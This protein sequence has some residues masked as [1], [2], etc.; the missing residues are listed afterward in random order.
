MVP[1]PPHPHPAVQS[2]S[3]QPGRSPKGNALKEF[4]LSR[5]LTA[6]IQRRGLKGEHP[7][8]ALQ[9]FLLAFLATAALR[10]APGAEAATARSRPR[11]PSRPPT[12]S[13]C[14][15]LIM[16]FFFLTSPN[17]CYPPRPPGTAQVMGTGLQTPPPSLG[18]E[19]PPQA[20]SHCPGAFCKAKV[21]VRV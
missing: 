15:Y 21:E 14:S 4:F 19:L 8:N 18:A 17:N 6:S 12:F 7:L 20:R 9:M 1:A 13:S 2:C 5:E 10:G 3:A 16:I 11:F